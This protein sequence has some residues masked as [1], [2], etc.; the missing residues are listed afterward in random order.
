MLDGMNDIMNAAKVSGAS[1]TSEGGLL[2][3]QWAHYHEVHAARR[4]LAIHIAT[5]P[6]FLA[7]TLAAVASPFVAWWLAPAGLVG[8]IAAVAAQGKGHAIEANPPLPFRSG[9][10]AVGRIFF[11]Q[12]FTFPRYVLTGRFARAWRASAQT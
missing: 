8:M 11:E 3:R 9:A 10:E 7:G 12:W 6:M 4:N 5:V 1:D 2:A